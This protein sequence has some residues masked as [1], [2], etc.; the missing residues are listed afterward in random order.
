MTKR[1]EYAEAGLPWYWVVAL[2]PPEILVLRN[3]GG[4]FVEHASAAGAE[5]LTL[6]EP[7][8]VGLR[9]TDLAT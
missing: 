7:V 1:G 4:A 5:R 9:P 6:G 2:E 3:S 8:A